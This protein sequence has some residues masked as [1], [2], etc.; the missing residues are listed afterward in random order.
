M[1]RTD[2]VDRHTQSNHASDP[3]AVSFLRELSRCEIDKVAKVA[4][5]QAKAYWQWKLRMCTGMECLREECNEDRVQR[6][7]AELSQRMCGLRKKE[8][9]NNGS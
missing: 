7:I 9:V 1:S 4:D 5:R 8:L 6:P 3:I 2:R